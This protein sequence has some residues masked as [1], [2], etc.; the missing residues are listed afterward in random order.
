MRKKTRE[1]RAMPPLDERTWRAVST[2]LCHPERPG[3]KKST[4]YIHAAAILLSSISPSP[5]N[6]R[7]LEVLLP[8]TDTAS[9][10][11]DARDTLAARAIHAAAHTA[12]A[13]SPACASCL[14]GVVGM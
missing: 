13:A 14:V 9:P 4:A 3:D 7:A 11:R 1:K 12:R 5:C 2:Q 6:A 10:S 8:L